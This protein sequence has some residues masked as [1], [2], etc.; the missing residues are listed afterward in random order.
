MSATASYRGTGLTCSGWTAGNGENDRTCDQDENAV[1]LDGAD[2]EAHGGNVGT[3]VPNAS[4]TKVSRPAKTRGLPAD[5]KTNQSP[6]TAA[7]PRAHR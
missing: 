6:L 1:T 2:G 3:A 7:R 4:I 5:H